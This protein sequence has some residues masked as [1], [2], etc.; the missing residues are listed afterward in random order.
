MTVA[1]RQSQRGITF[2]SLLFY[3]LAV[4]AGIFAILQ[5]GPTVL[6]YKAVKLALQRV[7]E[8]NPP[9]VAEAKRQFERQ[10]EADPTIRSVTSA[11]L[12]VTKDGGQVVISAKWERELTIVGPVSL[13]IHYEASSR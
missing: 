7:V 3:G 1:S 8:S 12:D 10:R 6:E 4:A 11:D 5:V 2:F 13:L 9:T